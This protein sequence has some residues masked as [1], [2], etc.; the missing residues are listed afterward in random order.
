[1]PEKKICLLAAVDRN[2]GIGRQNHL[3]F[4]LK[5]DM[6]FFAEKTKGN[7]VVM[8]R[9]TLE[10]LP[11]GRPLGERTNIVLTRQAMEIEGAVVAHSLEEV[12][13]FVKSRKEE[14]F[15]VGGGEIYRQYLDIASEAYITKVDAVREADVYFPNLDRMTDWKM[16]SSS[17][18][19]CDES[20][21]GLEFVTYVQ[22]RLSFRQRTPQPISGLG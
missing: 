17:G 6:R 14:V 18:R 10:S 11:G 12:M 3:L 13:S 9:K 7:I 2:W 4:H 15:V 1:M 21:I 5:Q 19:L 8:G 16:I 20:G 22:G